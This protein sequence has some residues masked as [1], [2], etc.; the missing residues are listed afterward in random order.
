MAPKK[1]WHPLK[2]EE[3][4]N[5]RYLAADPSL[6]AFGLVFIEVHEGQVYVQEAEKLSTVQT[7]A[8]G[9]ESNFRRAEEL[10]QLLNAIINRWIGDWGTGLFAVHEAPPAGG[11]MVQ[12]PESSILGG[13]EFRRVCTEFLL[14]IDKLVTPQSHKKLICG[15]HIASKKQHH[16]AVRELLPKI[17]DSRLISNE[18]LRDT[19]SVA[20]YAAHRLGESEPT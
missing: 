4:P 9:W 16:D 10:Y 13:R 1:S 11:G 20:L 6:S 12:R 17:H 2:L 7:E 3:L 8:G 18:A 14:P 5:C 15:N 19:L